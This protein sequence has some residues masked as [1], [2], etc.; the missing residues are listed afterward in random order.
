MKVTTITN[1]QTLEKDLLLGVKQVQLD[2]LILKT[3]PLLV[4]PITKK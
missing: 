1:I 4:K 2:S 3:I